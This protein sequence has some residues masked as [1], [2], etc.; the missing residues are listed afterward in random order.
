MLRLQSNV[1]LPRTIRPTARG[2][3]RK[4]PFEAM[5]LDDFFFVPGISTQQIYGHV[6]NTGRK[7]GKV[8][9]VRLSYM[10]QDAAGD[11]QPCDQTDVGA[12]LGVGVW[13]TE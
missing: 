3:R 13:R 5:Q 6:W 11:W 1:P 10:K 8:F 9:K 2:R 7:L 4:Y 12:T